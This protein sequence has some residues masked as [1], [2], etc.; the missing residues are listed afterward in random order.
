MVGIWILLSY[1]KRVRS[2]SSRGSPHRERFPAGWVIGKS[3]CSFRLASV[4]IDAPGRVAM[5]DWTDA[6]EEGAICR[7]CRIPMGPPYQDGYCDNCQQNRS[8]G[9]QPH[10]VSTGNVA[11]SAIDRARAWKEDSGK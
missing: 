11:D 6:M 4:G 3:P 7:G 5:G 10:S 9:S 2:L 8:F 1:K